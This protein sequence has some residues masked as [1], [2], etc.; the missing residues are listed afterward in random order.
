M[1]TYLLVHGAW[2]GGWC[3]D[4]VRP[5]LEAAGHDVLTPSL[6]G[7]GEHSHLIVPDIGL[8][9][10]VRDIE[11]LVRSRD[12]RDFVLCGHS[13]GGMVVTA[14]ADRMPD[15]IRA[16]VYVDAFLPEE[17]E[18]VV[19]LT[20][21]DRRRRLYTSARAL[22]DGWRVPP[23]PAEAFGLDPDDCGWV[24][25]RCTPQPLATLEEP[26]RLAGGLARLRD[27]TYVAA[28][29]PHDMAIFGP[30]RDRARARGWAVRG[31]TCGHEIMLDRP[32]ELAQI[33]LDL[34]PAGT[35]PVSVR[36]R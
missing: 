9:T 30:F 27:V 28:E 4:R 26:V 10:H 2:H 33:L 23:I 1:T 24:N 14:L 21:A 3:W 17:G 7:L 25:A 35:T 5:I 20:P 36:L 22:G 29:A 13:Y 19:G 12:L 31:V 8:G 18:N 34:L 15:R 6:A 32:R 11:D 16:L